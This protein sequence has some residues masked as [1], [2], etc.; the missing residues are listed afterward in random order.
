MNDYESKKEARIERY[1]ERAATAKQRGHDAYKRGREIASYIPFGQPIL[2]GHHS[3][4]GHRR[5]LDRIDRAYGQSYAESE[6][7][8]YWAQRAEAAENNR[9][10]SGDDPEAVEKI[11]A[12]IDQLNARHERMKAVNAAHKRYLKKPET[13]DTAKFSDDEKTFIRNYKSAYSWERHPFPSYKLTNNNANI[14][15]LEQRLV[16]LAREPE[17]AAAPIEGEHITIT[18]D[19]ER[20]RIEVEFDAKPT[21]EV[22]KRLKESGF[23]WTPSEGVWQRRRVSWARVVVE[24]IARDFNL[25][26]E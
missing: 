12:K 9:A 21:A 18:E 7:A 23:R 14:R 5:D 2:V 11:Q 6:K 17:P 19:A 3:E 13:L 16:Y 24:Q 15:R 1:R 22:R 25:Q 20:D 4:K 10:I 26:A 8:K